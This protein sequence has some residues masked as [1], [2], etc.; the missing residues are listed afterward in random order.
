MIRAVVAQSYP[1]ILPRPNVRSIGTVF[2]AAPI[3]SSIQCIGEILKQARQH[4]GKCP[5]GAAANVK[6]TFQS[7]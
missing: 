2:N 1:L 5:P 7:G 6:L 3:T 4:S